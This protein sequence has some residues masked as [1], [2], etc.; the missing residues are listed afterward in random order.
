MT[1]LFF[2]PIAIWF[3][4]PALV[5]T[6][7]FALR[8]TLML[9]GGDADADA[10]GVDGDFDLTDADSVGESGDTGESTA[11]FEILSLQAISA[12]LMGFGW[13][14]LGAFRGSGWPPIA[15]VLVGLVTGAAMVWLLGSM[16]RFMLRLQSSG[17]LPMY[18]ALEAEGSVYAQ[19]PAAGEGK[20]EVRVVIGDR[21]RYYRAITAGSAI[22]TGAKVRVVSVN[23]DDNSVTV[24]EA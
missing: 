15:A 17:N 23:D 14:G 24:T 21:E 5:G 19:I 11:A 6:A 13:G 8:T 16:L 18:Q 22:P 7:F 12:F 3:G 10:M 20:G 9:V 1:D 4:V 2:G